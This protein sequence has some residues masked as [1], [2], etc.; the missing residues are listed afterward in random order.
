MSSRHRRR[1]QQEKKLKNSL[2]DDDNTEDDIFERNLDDV[3]SEK[4]ANAFRLLQEDCSSSESEGSEEVDQESGTN[5]R[6]AKIEVQV[7]ETTSSRSINKPGRSNRC[8]ETEE[9]EDEY[10]ILAEAAK[11][12][13]LASL[14][15][16][17]A[18]ALDAFDPW[19]LDPMNL[20]VS[21]RHHIR[22]HA[23]TSLSDRI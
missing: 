2:D 3:S 5:V 1:A 19:R 6:E 14:A 16:S 12:S 13:A 22:Q 4:K 15:P 23:H 11:E 10:A 21:T 18:E 17:S 8:T 20:E 7:P 9:D